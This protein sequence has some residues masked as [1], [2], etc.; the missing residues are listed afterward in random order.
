VYTKLEIAQ[1]LLSIL[2]PSTTIDSKLTIQEAMKA[3]SQARDEFVRN[4]ILAAKI[5]T[6]VVNGNWLS[7]FD[8][9]PA[10]YDE[11]RCKW[12]V[13]LPTGIIALPE[14]MGVYQVWYCNHP[15]DFLVPVSTGFMNRYRYSYAQLLEGKFGYYLAENRLYLLQDATNET[16][17]GMN[18]VSQSED[19]EEYDYF[20]IDGASVQAV[21]QRAVELYSVQKQI[22]EDILNNNVSE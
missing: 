21:L 11:N 12:Y 16:L 13:E 1:R 7:T 2:Y 22:N 14:D 20:P 19:L 6:N 4:N 15:E 10:K 3:V 8:K 9:V 18:L 5:D 17:F